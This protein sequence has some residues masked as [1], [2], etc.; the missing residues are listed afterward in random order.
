MELSLKQFCSLCQNTIRNDRIYFSCNHL[1]CLHCFPFILLNII[2]SNGIK[3]DFFESTRTQFSCIICK[4]GQTNLPFDQISKHFTELSN[5]KA[6]RK[7]S[8]IQICERCEENP[9]IQYC[10]T[11]KFNFC[12][13]CLNS[14]HETRAFKNHQIEN[15]Q[16]KKILNKCLCGENIEHF[17]L[18]CLLGI[19][20]FCLN[21]EHNNHKKTSY[22]KFVSK[23]KEI[24]NLDAAKQ[25]LLTLLGDFSIFR[26]DF[27]KSLN[28]SLKKEHEESDKLFDNIFNLLKNLQAKY[29][30]NLSIRK[31]NLEAKFSLI[32]SSLLTLYDE[33]ERKENLIPNKLYQ[34]CHFFE[35]KQKFQLKNFD[36][37]QN[38]QLKEIIQILEQD[39]RHFLGDGQIKANSLPTEGYFH[40]HLINKDDYVYSKCYENF[41]SNPVELFD[42]QQGVLLEKE[43]F[44]PI[45]P[46]SNVSCSFFLNNKTFL[47]W[48]GGIVDGNK[49]KGPIIFYDLSNRKR[50]IE[51]QEYNSS[52]FLSTVISTYPKYGFEPKRWLFSGDNDGVLRIYDLTSQLQPFS[53]VHKIETNLGK[54]I[55]SAIIFDDRFNEIEGNQSAKNK[56]YAFITFDDGN[57]PIR[58]YSFIE[59]EGNYNNNNSNWEI[60]TEIPN[61]LKKECFTINFFHDEEL[62]KTW[63]FFG[64]CFNIINYDLKANKWGEKQFKT[65]DN[66]TSIQ[67][68]FRERKLLESVRNR[69]NQSQF[70]RFLIY[71]CWYNNTI[72]VADINTGDISRKVE[73]LN[74]ESIN[75]ICL[76][77]NNKFGGS[78]NNTSNNNNAG[79]EN[80]LIVVTQNQNSI[81]ILNFEDLSILHCKELV[82]SKGKMIIIPTNVIKVLTKGNDDKDFKEGLIYFQTTV[83]FKDKENRQIILFE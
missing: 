44:I 20:E 60:Y 69:K 57:L 56:I 23:C 40:S 14:V 64:F 63:I 27:M 15:C 21:K 9:A 54:A 6:F 51:L 49:W 43:N 7:I 18:E 3:N 2:A 52:N 1:I 78:N 61:P 67:F 11:C 17:C 81:K 31:K 42:K 76:W 10:R 33:I 26:N 79:L 82:E 47:A 53:Q 5:E 38:H 41:K 16:I 29:A 59:N 32:H 19:C 66:V 13:K 75:D 35:I 50:E 12:R 37:V 24:I 45:W 46:K 55:L 74:V 34:F 72:V 8:K 25:S 73:L 28:I 22:Q 68:L 30:N 71:T 58:M 65:S 83:E 4:N 39:N 70:E 62:L 36:F 80:Y 77:N 48:A